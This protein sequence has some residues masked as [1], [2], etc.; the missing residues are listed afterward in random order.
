L[1]SSI[2]FGA[3]CE[4]LV[5]I[6]EVTLSTGNSESGCTD[7]GASC[8]ALLCDGFECPTLNPVWIP[9]TTPGVGDA[10]GVSSSIAVDNLE[11][12]SGRSALHLTV[13]PVASNAIGQA[14]LAEAT[15]LPLTPMSAF[16]RA[17]FYVARTVEASFPLMYYAQSGPPYDGSYIEV[18]GGGG[19]AAAALTLV[20]FANAGPVDL[21]KTVPIGAWF[22]VEWEVD[23]APQQQQ[24][25]WV[26]DGSGA[27]EQ[28]L[29]GFNR[30]QATVP[31]PPLAYFDLGPILYYPGPATTSA[32]DVWVDDVVADTQRIQCR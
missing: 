8:S 26:D 14:F 20:D 30:V 23:F 28:E 17:W 3:S 15:T 12:H 9:N 5:G 31:S 10:A 32:I 1:L 13:G 11:V 7:G 29:T 16:V 18:G 24:R 19:P 25:V 21:G 6:P 4:L 2:A 22:C 27:G